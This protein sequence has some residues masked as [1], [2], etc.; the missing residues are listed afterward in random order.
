MM[1]SSRPRTGPSPCT[2]G[3]FTDTKGMPM[4]IL[5]CFWTTWKKRTGPGILKEMSRYEM[6]VMSPFGLEDM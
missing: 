3:Q 6:Q 4:M 5:D 1:I 2:T